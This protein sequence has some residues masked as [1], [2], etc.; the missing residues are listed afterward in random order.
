MSEERISS[1]VVGSNYT[2]LDVIGEGA[3][4]VVWYV[5]LPSVP[6]RCELTTRRKLCNAPTISAQGGH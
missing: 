5:L 3:Y 4:G 1:F 2:V 6:L